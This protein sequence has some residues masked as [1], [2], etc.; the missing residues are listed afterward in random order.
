MFYL[1]Y[2]VL[3]SRTAYGKNKKNVTYYAFKPIQQ[4]K[5]ELMIVPYK[6]SSKEEQTNVYIVATKNEIQSQYSSHI[7]MTIHQILGPVGVPE[8]EQKYLLYKHSLAP[9]T[10]K[11][12]IQPKQY[13][14]SII[15]EEII[16]RNSTIKEA[17]TID[18]EGSQDHDDAISICIH[19]DQT[20]TIG[21][22]IADVSFLVS[23]DSELDK[24]A[25][26]SN[27]TTVYPSTINPLNMLPSYVCNELLSLKEKANKLCVSVYY[28]YTKENILKDK[29]IARDTVRVI[30]NC[31]YEN[32]K[33]EMP[34]QQWKTLQAI[35]QTSDSH[36]VVEYFMLQ[37]NEYIAQVLAQKNSEEC[38][39][40]MQEANEQETENEFYKQL[41]SNRAEYILGTKNNKKGHVSLQKDYYTHFTS[42]LRRYADIIAHRQLFL[43]HYKAPEKIIKNINETNK[44]CS[45]LKSDEYKLQLIYD[46]EERWKTSSIPIYLEAMVMIIEEEYI[47]VHAKYKEKDFLLRI[48]VEKEVKQFQKLKIEIIPYLCASIFSKKLK[49]KVV[50]I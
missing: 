41:C 48:K 27:Y 26:E 45:K 42:P 33:K 2:V 3:N 36:K 39:L 21:V 17:Y 10:K 18:P 20:K 12:R 31:T 6:K 13:L 5:D 47:F 29:K 23:P 14:Q 37:T 16:K 44:R 38:I 34:K 43:Q 15:D 4:E 11:P 25:K 49:L 22:H 40:R 9:L 1:G 8:A 35:A 28:T 19:E 30:K 46:L 32:V 50:D 7:I 24:Y